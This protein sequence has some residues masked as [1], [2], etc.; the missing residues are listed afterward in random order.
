MFFECKKFT[1]NLSNW[2]VT[3]GL[4]FNCMFYECKLFNADLSKWD[5]S[6]ATSWKD[7]AKGS[8]LKKYP[9]RI[10]EKFRGDYL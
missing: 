9:E 8:L 6:N 4:Y 10:P 1:A 2:D 3:K 7:F 5:V